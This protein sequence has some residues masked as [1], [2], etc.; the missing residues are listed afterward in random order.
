MKQLLAALAA[1]LT[2]TTTA[3]AQSLAG[4]WEATINTPGGPR[5]FA[6]VFQVEGERVS[7]TVK[8]PAGEVPLTGTI[9]ADTVQFSYTVIYNDN[10]LLLTVLAKLE[11]DSLTGTI[12]F[13]GAAQDEFSAKRAKKAPQGPE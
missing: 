12:D 10:P 11:G 2:V 13:G 3:S 7:G 6:I 4:E 5:T 8:R 1:A 9:K